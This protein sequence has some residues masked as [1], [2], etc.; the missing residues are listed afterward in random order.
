[1]AKKILIVLE[2]LEQ[3]MDRREGG[4]IKLFKDDRLPA[5]ENEHGLQVTVAGRVRTVPPAILEGWKGA[6]HVRVEDA[7]AT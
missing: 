7:P 4:V 3:G 1:M 6:G 5:I 2:T